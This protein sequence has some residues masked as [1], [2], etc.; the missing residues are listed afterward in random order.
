MMVEPG[1]G[2]GLRPVLSRKGKLPAHLEEE[3]GEGTSYP[4]RTSCEVAAF[5]RGLILY[6]KTSST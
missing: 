4:D 2:L 6:F 5:R 3:C 1:Y